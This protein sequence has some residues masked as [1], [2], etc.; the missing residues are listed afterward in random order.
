MEWA[1]EK[2]RRWVGGEGE[3]HVA[4]IDDK[5]PLDGFLQMSK[6]RIQ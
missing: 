1:M 2:E 6:S 4:S 3:M 5:E